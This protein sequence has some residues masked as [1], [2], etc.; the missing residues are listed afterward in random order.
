[1]ASQW[2]SFIS[3]V[4]QFNY[5][6]YGERETGLA[7]VYR[8]MQRFSHESALYLKGTIVHICSQRELWSIFKVLHII[9]LGIH[10]FV[11]PMPF[12][13]V[14]N[15]TTYVKCC[16]MCWRYTNKDFYV[17]ISYFTIR[18]IRMGH[19]LFMIFYY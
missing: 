15:F 14:I 13:S 11:T 8:R 9:V 10:I 3:S 2:I 12:Y 4:E 18:F 7:C 6:D 19:F 1:M 17:K 5:Y 16:R